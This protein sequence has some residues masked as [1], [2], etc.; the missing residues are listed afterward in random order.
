MTGGRSCHPEKKV[1][2]LVAI[3]KRWAQYPGRSQL[4][5]K[6][7]GLTVCDGLTSPQ[8]G[9]RERSWF[10]RTPSLSKPAPLCACSEVFSSFKTIFFTEGATVISCHG[11]PQCR[12]RAAWGRTK[13][14]FMKQG[15]N[16]LKE[17]GPPG[18]AQHFRGSTARMHRSPENQCHP[19]A[20]QALATTSEQ[21]PSWEWG[22]SYPWGKP[23][24]QR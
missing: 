23:F 6:A 2:N 5:W 1:A 19:V 3:R 4:W 8:D 21:M 13:T 17:Y 11:A 14:A 16:I 22:R 18:A 24:L 15:S 12:S 7:E 9:P 20:P 10:S